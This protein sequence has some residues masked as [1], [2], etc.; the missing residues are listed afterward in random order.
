MPILTEMWCKQF[1][2]LHC[3][4]CSWF[5]EQLGITPVIACKARVLSNRPYHLTGVGNISGLFCFSNST[6]CHALA[7]ILFLWL[8]SYELSMVE[9]KDKKCTAQSCVVYLG[10]GEEEYRVFNFQESSRNAWRMQGIKF[11]FSVD[12]TSAKSSKVF[13]ASFYCYFRVIILSNIN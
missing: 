5:L 8:Y 4:V 9:T 1:G 2:Y 3:V 7:T 11:R 6:H 12:N 10:V 13:Q